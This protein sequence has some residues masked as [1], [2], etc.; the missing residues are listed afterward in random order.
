[1]GAKKPEPQKLLADWIEVFKPTDL[2]PAN[3]KRR[4]K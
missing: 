3:Q 1:V 4:R 2:T